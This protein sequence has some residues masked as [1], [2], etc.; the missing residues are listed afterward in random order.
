MVRRRPCAVSNHE[1]PAV[2]TSFE[3]RPRRRSSGRGDRA[4]YDAA[5]V[6]GDWLGGF[7]GDQLPK[8][9]STLA[10]LDPPQQQRQQDVDPRRKLRVLPFFG[11]GRMMEAV[12]G[13]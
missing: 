10:R 12:G 2:A 4:V 8:R 1:A 11:M 6:R 5:T 3:T 9:R 13:L 7:S